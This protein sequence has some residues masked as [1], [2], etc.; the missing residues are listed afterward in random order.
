MPLS[1]LN[2]GGMGGLIFDDGGRSRTDELT[3][4]GRDVANAS[5]RFVVTAAGGIEGSEITAGLVNGFIVDSVALGVIA[6]ESSG[7]GRR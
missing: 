6:R 5:D 1:Y 4:N 2:I 3:V 7:S